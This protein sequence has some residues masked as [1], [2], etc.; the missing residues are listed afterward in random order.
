MD[1]KACVVMAPEVSLK[2]LPVMMTVVLGAVEK[3]L[4]SQVTGRC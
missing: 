2:K 1:E 4:E 3:K